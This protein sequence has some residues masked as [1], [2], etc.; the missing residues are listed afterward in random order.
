MYLSLILSLLV[1]T[2]SQMNEGLQGY[3]NFLNPG[4]ESQPGEE[5]IP[6]VDR[7][8]GQCATW[9]AHENFRN[10]EAHQSG[11]SQKLR[12]TNL[13]FL[14]TDVCDYLVGHIGFN[15]TKE[16]CVGYKKYFPKMKVFYSTGKYQTYIY[17]YTGELPGDALV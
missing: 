6:T 3:C 14:S 1:V 10:L 8:W 7:N 12:E 5:S 9:C 11:P 17:I 2:N 4:R 13:D 16:F 15:K